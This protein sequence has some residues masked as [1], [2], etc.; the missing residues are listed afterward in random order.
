[1][2]KRLVDF[3]GTGGEGC[4]H[5][6]TA[7]APLPAPLPATSGR[8]TSDLRVEAHASGELGRLRCIFDS[9]YPCHFRSDR[10][11]NVV[12]DRE[13][14]GRR[15]FL[16]LGDQFG[17]NCGR[18]TRRYTENCV[19]RQIIDARHGHAGFRLNAGEKDVERVVAQSKDRR[20]QVENWN[21][22]ET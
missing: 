6:A 16:D 22:S 18:W 8:I 11:S 21:W 1:M 12:G 13:P 2:V 5:P 20:C 10:R 9:R 17:H 15:T 3:A 4:P 19:A 7:T 14:I